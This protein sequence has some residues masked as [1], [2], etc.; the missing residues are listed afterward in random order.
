MM[1]ALL[2]AARRTSPLILFLDFDGTLVPIQTDPE[3]VRITAARKRLL[4]KLAR[5][6]PTAVVTGRSLRDIQSR[7]NLPG[8]AWAGNHGLEV[9]QGRVLWRHPGAEQTVPILQEVLR[10]TERRLNHIPGLRFDDKGLS[11]SV[12]YRRAGAGRAPEILRILRDVV[13]TGPGRLKVTRGKMVFEI[14]PAVR[15]DKG[16][17]VRCLQARLDPQRRATPVYLGDDRTDEDA[18]RALAGRGLTVCIGDRRP[19]AARYRLPDVAAVW[20]FLGSLL[21]L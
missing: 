11:A 14:R 12:H 15:W 5:R 20:R 9:L 13:P 10:T 17:A 1:R 7:T 21:L 19:T 4:A 6:F 2:E 18:F 3:T 8:I 16:K